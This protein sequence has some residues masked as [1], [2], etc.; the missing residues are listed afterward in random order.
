VASKGGKMK[1]IFLILIL[2]ALL[3]VVFVLMGGGRWLKSAGLWIGGVGSKAEDVKQTI[4]KK[5]QGVEKSVEK[6]IEAVKPG[7]KK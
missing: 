6:G 3:T 2:V 5:A 4:E 7:E 1:R